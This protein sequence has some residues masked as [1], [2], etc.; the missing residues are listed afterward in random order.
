MY[1]KN[2][3][4]NLGKGQTRYSR[5]IN[6]LRYSK[7]IDTQHIEKTVKDALD[8]LSS[9][10]KSFVI[11]GEPQSGKTEMMIALTDKLLDEGHNIVIV[12]LN[13]ND[14]LLAQNLDRFIKSSIDPMPYDVSEILGENIGDKK[15]V[16]FSKKNNKILKKLISKLH[17][18]SGMIIIDDEADYA[19]PNARVNKDE[20]TAINKSIYNLLGSDGIYIGVT[21][22]PARLDMNNTFD[23]I[24]ENWVYFGTHKDYVGKDTFFPLDLSYAPQF[25]PDSGDDPI[26]LQKALLSFL[27]NVGYINMNTD[28]KDGL[29]ASGEENAN[30]CFLV[31]TSGRTADH[32]TDERIVNNTIDILSGQENESYDKFVELMYNIAIEKYDDENATK[33]VKFVILNIGSKRTEVMN[34]ESKKARKFQIDLTNPPALFTIVIGG[35]IISRGMTFN[36]LLGM[37]FTRD[38]GHKMQQDTYI[39][40]ARMF[41]NRRKYLEFFEL[42]VPRPLYLDWHRCFVYH[43]LSLEAIR[44]YKTA[45]VWISDDRV[46][47]M[48][49]GSIDRSV[50]VTDAGQMY[51]STFPY[52]EEINERIETILAKEANELRKLELMNEM[53]GDDKLPRYFVDFIRANSRPY[54]GYIAIHTPRQV[55]KETDYHDTLYRPK[56]VIGGQEMSRFPQAIH[57]I[58]VIRNHYGQARIVYTYKGR[59][60]FASR[61]PKRK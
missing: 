61:R 49:P 53:L 40:R 13:D 21:A 33:A 17:N 39:Q 37:F 1:D 15:W 32:K 45:P 20:R 19:S 3:F 26:H 38:V 56:G 54:H 7:G 14:Q 46:R 8:N 11:Y 24:A 5:R 27:V 25:L 29:K 4:R 34:V 43:Y 50:V 55:G 9:G 22:T 18:K 28:I 51:F 30:F 42:W 16:I 60:Q 2:K 12:L 48:A 47:P 35:N 59:V 36:N 57:H 58:M 10:N 31:H 23:N 52:N 6:I 44:T 41:G